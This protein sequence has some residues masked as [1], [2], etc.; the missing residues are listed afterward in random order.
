M[1]NPEFERVPLIAVYQRGEVT[2]L[3]LEGRV[4]VE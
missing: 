1:A 2:K 3:F 4:E